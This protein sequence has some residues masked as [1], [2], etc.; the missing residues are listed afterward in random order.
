MAEYDGEITLSMKVTPEEV[1]KS[2]QELQ[3]EIKKVFEMGASTPLDKKMKSMETNLDKL[4]NKVQQAGQNLDK[5]LN[6]KVPTEEYTE[7]SNIIATSE[8]ELD[9]LI[10]KQQTLQRA[11]SASPLARQYEELTNKMKFY[12]EAIQKAIAERGKESDAVKQLQVEQLQVKTELDKIAPKLDTIHAKSSQITKEINQRT[13]AI[14]DNKAEL[15]NLVKSGKA[16]TLDYNAITK[17]KNDEAELNNQLRISVEE[18]KNYHSKLVQINEQEKIA[19]NLKVAEERS[20]QYLLENAKI[21]NKEIAEKVN[22]AKILKSNID[23]MKASQEQM[24]NL[25]IGPGYKQFDE[26]SQSIAKADSEYQKLMSDID[27]YN[28]KMQTVPKS[29]LGVLDSFKK[30]PSMIADVFKHLPSIIGNIFKKILSVA[31][32]VLSKI[33]DLLKKIPSAI[34]TGVKAFTK[35][36]KAILNNIPG[37]RQLSNLVGKLGSKFLGLGKDANTSSLNF[38]K[39]FSTVLKYGLGIRGLFVLFRK[40]RSAIVEGVNNLAQTKGGMNATNEALSQ[41]MSS[42]NALKNSWGAAFA[43]MLQVVAPILA[44]F[45]DMITQFANKLNMLIS[46]LLGRTTA[47]VAKKQSANYAE[48][49]DKTGTASGRKQQEKYDAAVEKANKKYEE[50]VAKVNQKNAEAQAKAEEKQAKAAE[51][52]A[53]KQEKANKQLGAYDQLNVIA[54]E[55]AE[56]LEDIQAKE[57]EMPE[58]ELPD[59]A[60]YM[61][62]MTDFDSMFEEVPIE[63]AIQGLIDKIKEAWETGD[64]TELG[65]FVG[66]KLKE[67]LDEATEWIVNVAQPFASKLGTAIATFTNGLV[68]VDGLAASFGQTLG[69]VLNTCADFMTGI[70]DNL[71]FEAIGQFLA[72]GIQSFLNTVDFSQMGHNFAQWYNGLFD[73]IKGFA[74]H[75]DPKVFAKAVGDFVNTAINDFE[76]GENAQSLSKFAIKFF[77]TITESIKAVEWNKLGEDVAE[78]ISNI[79]WAG[80]ASSLFEAIGA[81]L[82]GFAAFLEGLIGDAWNAVVEW[83][84]DVAYEDGEFTIEGLLNGI[85]EALKDIGEWIKK[86]IFDPFIKGFKDA[87]KISSP[88]KVMDEEGGFLMDGL[89]QGISDKIASVVAKFTELKNKIVAVFNTLKTNVISVWNT[90]WSGIKSVI[91]SILG[92]IEKMCNGVISGFNKLISGINNL[93]IDI[94]DWIPEEWGGGKSIGFNIPELRNI[95]IP[96]LA[97]GAVIPPNK[98]FMA[99]L[100]DQKSGTNI[101]APLDTIMEALNTVL[102]SRDVNSNHEPIVLQLDSRT[103]AECVWDEEEKRYKQRGVSYS[104]MFT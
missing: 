86:N 63:S 43:P 44:K 96:R 15:D 95:S 56:E 98:E 68:E 5:A 59:M 20:N 91:N 65:S 49:L 10:K 9:A 4:N 11:E 70:L 62:G 54:K 42:L 50:K 97:Q 45:I 26:L 66:E 85:G 73:A 83:W 64:F 19:N 40:L 3:R 57:Y 80:V 12:D 67:K 6:T 8:K 61:T 32:T 36:S 29:T 82:G 93:N 13:E 25:G 28:Q 7:L 2:S 78:F 88:S 101:E 100:G 53:K 41:L 55:D 87:F 37:I 46:G 14:K 18:A 103:V 71:N 1:K 94:P 58:L 30:L 17:A 69:E 48:S 77:N 104:P 74:D 38:K 24:Q 34:E 35:L 60:D 76:W 92:G 22:K 84:Y 31:K 27:V 89:K 21:Q 81:A 47:I 79:D 39:L 90:M 51:K 16:F 33:P 102:D 52:L 23:A 99:M 72:D 75:W